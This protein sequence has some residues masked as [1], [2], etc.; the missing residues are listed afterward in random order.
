MNSSIPILDVGKHLW[1]NVIQR[2][3]CSLSWFPAWLK[4]FKHLNAFLR[5]LTF[6]EEMCKDIRKKG[7]E[8]KVANT[9]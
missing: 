6:V 3:L 1:D 5:N 8:F 2:G 4:K 9:L 7:W